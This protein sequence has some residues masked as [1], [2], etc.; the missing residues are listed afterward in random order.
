[1]ADA[2]ES[3]RKGVASFKGGAEAAGASELE[4]VVV[5]MNAPTRRIVKVERIDKAGKRKI[6]GVSVSLSE[7]E[8]HWREFLAGLVS[9]GLSGVRLIVSDAHE[10]LAAARRAV[11]PRCRRSGRRRR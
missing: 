3:E 4:Q 9:R 1:M 10:G 6:L 5:T 8:V 2:Q 11:L 7:A